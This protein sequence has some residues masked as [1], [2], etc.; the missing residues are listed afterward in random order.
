MWWRHAFRLKTAHSLRAG[1]ISARRD[2][3]LTAKKRNLRARPKQSRR[4]LKRYRES[5]KGGL[6]FAEKSA[7]LISAA[8]WHCRRS[9]PN[10]AHQFKYFDYVAGLGSFRGGFSTRFVGCRTKR[11][12]RWDPESSY[13]DRIHYSDGEPQ[14]DRRQP[15]FEYQG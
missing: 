15:K 1:L 5:I 3:S 13:R 11:A 12:H 9:E 10:D 8:K 7:V 2:K 6:S 14:L 4:A